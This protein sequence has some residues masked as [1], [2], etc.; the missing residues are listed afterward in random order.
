MT[1]FMRFFVLIAHPYA[2]SFHLRPLV[3]IGSV[4]CLCPCSS[5]MRYIPKLRV[6]MDTAPFYDRRH[7]DAGHV[8]TF[9]FAIKY[10]SV[11]NKKLIGR[12]CA[13]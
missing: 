6:H 12:R 7:L 13:L 1:Q 2:I 4:A 8:E 9:F 5:H 10:T 3:S 11:C